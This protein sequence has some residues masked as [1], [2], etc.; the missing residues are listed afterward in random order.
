MLCLH[1]AS[2]Y[3]SCRT[4]LSTILF[5]PTCKPI[6]S[7]TFINDYCH[8]CRVFWETHSVSEESRRERAAYFRVEEDYHGPITPSAVPTA[9]GDGFFFGF[10]K[11]VE[12]EVREQSPRNEMRIVMGPQD[13]GEDAR[14][15]S[16]LNARWEAD[17]YASIS[18][19]TNKSEKPASISSGSTIWPGTKQDDADARPKRLGPNDFGYDSDEDS[20][21]SRGHGLI[22][23]E[24]F[25]MANLERDLSAPLEKKGL[26]KH[27]L[28]LRPVG[29]MP[30]PAPHRI[31]R[32]TSR[33]DHD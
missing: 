7:E 6:N 4:L 18:A 19:M 29:S 9:G 17:D 13:V 16:E 24:E 27:D 21:W 12:H 14:Y 33:S 2:E 1:T 25:D 20:N 8:R 15:V 5:R 26:K 3:Q 23:P 28:S 31:G 11:D 30:S 22:D 10:I 32:E